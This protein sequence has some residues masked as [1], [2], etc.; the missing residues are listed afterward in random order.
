MSDQTPQPNHEQTSPCQGTKL[1]KKIV[2]AVTGSVGA[3]SAIPR[4]L[5]VLRSMIAEEVLVVLSE[6]AQ[7]FLTPYVAT[8]LSGQ[9]ALSEFYSAGQFVSPHIQCCNGADVLLVMPAT[10]NII[11]KA[12]NGIADDIVSATV[13]AATCPVVFVPNMNGAMW[14]KK[15]TQRNIARLKEDGYHIIEPTWGTEIANL[16]KTFGVMPPFPHILRE[17]AAVLGIRLEQAK[18]A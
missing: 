15:A 9:P 8:L 6:S 5:G 17:I 1:I 4:F 10:A 11:A 14:N 16:E 13:L 7:K 12:A 18:A 3:A 2:L